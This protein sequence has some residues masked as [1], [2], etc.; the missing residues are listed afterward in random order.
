MKFSFARRRYLL[1]AVLS[2]IACL[3]LA[4][5]GGGGS[6]SSSSS[7]ESGASA[8]SGSGSEEGSE[9]GGEAGGGES[10]PATA[11]AE[12][13]KYLGVPKFEPPPAFEASKAKGKF[14]WDVPLNSSLPFQ[15]GVDEGV[16]E[17]AKAAGLKLQYFQNQG[18]VSE[19]V[20]GIQQGITAKPDLILLDSAPNPAQVQP[21]IKAAQAAGI[22][23][24]AS[25]IPS[26]AEDSTHL[27]PPSNFANLTALTP[28]PYALSA[29]LIA[30]YAIANTPEGEVDAL[31]ITSEEN[32][33][34][35]IM[36]ARIEQKFE[37]LCEGCK[38]KVI[39]VAIPDWAKEVQPQVQTALQQDPDIN[40]VLPIY[41][42]ASQYV[43]PAIRAAGKV[44][45][46][47]ISTFNGTP[48]VLK[49][50]ADD[51]GEIVA[52]DVG[53]NIQQTGWA[54]IDQS[55]RI[56]SGAE[57]VEYEGAAVPVRV[58]TA[59]NVAEAGNPPS[60]SEGYGNTYKNEYLKTWGLSK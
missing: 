39:N 16:T 1:G 6:S 34:S 51:E 4:A 25:N 10:G 59:E 12:I 46:V 24:V 27:L 54:S 58:W 60:A 55:L 7:S 53:E 38:L 57:P 52:M 11:K 8:S 56:L 30:D 22:P 48:F 20:Q 43:I 26:E 45:Q 33:S 13:A 32:P 15:Q 37:E 14:V 19:W 41:D 36:K 49:E 23:V 31:A 50:M 42:T 21:Q 17:A 9:A 3:A 47:H 5:C 2:L 28:A 35:P 18:T 44:G 40:W 29:E